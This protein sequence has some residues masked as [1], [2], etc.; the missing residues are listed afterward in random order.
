MLMRGAESLVV[1]I[2]PLYVKLLNASIVL[3]LVG[4]VTSINRLG[5]VFATPIVGRWCDR[6]GYSK[7]L[8]IGVFVASGAC[9]LGGVS[10][11][12]IDLGLWRLLS[13]IGYG[14]VTL[15][16]LAFANRVTTLKNRATAMSLIH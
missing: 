12:A 11:G 14:T 3:S 5:T 2:L 15:A 16:T 13:G 9:V 6:I 7:P 4:L 10:F 8:M 1:P